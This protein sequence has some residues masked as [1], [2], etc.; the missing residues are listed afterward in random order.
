MVFSPTYL[1]RIL[2]LSERLLFQSNRASHVGQ[3]ATVSDSGSPVLT[4]GSPVSTEGPCLWRGPPVSQKCL[5][6]RFQV[7]IYQVIGLYRL[8][9]LLCAPEG[10]QTCQGLP[11]SARGPPVS[12]WDLLYGLLGLLC[13]LESLVYLAD[14]LLY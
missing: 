13:W 11:I 5:L 14:G 9:D 10:L 8:K 2:Y 6:S 4:E 12:T 1:E 3:R 7:L